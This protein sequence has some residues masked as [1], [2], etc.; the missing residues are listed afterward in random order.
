MVAAGGFVSARQ[1]RLGAV[2][3]NVLAPAGAAVRWGFAY[4]AATTGAEMLVALV[5]ARA[6]V[7]AHIVV[8][9]ALL[10]H[11]ARGREREQRL[12]WALTLGPLIRIMSLSL[13]LGRVPI[14]WWYALISVPLFVATALTIRA[15]AYRPAEV[16]LRL[17]LAD[18][19]TQLLIALVGLPLGVVEYII[20]QPVPLARELSLAA[21]WLPGVIL[22]IS[23]G[24]LE[25]IIFRGVLQRA[26]SEAIGPFGGPLLIS[27]LFTALHIGYKSWLDLVFVFAA[28]SLFAFFAARTRSI[29]GVTLAHGLVNSVLF[30]IG[31][32]V[33]GGTAV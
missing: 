16:G 29:W 5:D 3:L 9:L 20:L 11:G 8:L 4:L 6:G 1:R 24:F 23:T 33:L 22:L 15:L 2:A 28:G 17:Q 14:V 18:I 12:F 32:F 25:E 27:M 21:I 13:P 31:P 7:S 30:L 26:S 19:P 10:V